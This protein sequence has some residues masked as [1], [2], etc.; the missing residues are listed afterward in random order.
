MDI[1]ATKLSH[2]KNPDMCVNDKAD[3]A[4]NPLTYFF[5]YCID[6]KVKILNLNTFFFSIDPSWF[7]KDFYDMIILFYL[8][9]F[10]FCNLISLK[11]L[12]NVKEILINTSNNCIN[13]LTNFNI[14]TFYKCIP[15]INVN[16][17]NW[18]K[19]NLN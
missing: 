13:L 16:V 2:G 9:F 7:P 8:Y 12:L 4:F 17:N 19:P 18:S 5:R 6:E 1:L 11:F 15:I 10:L 3:R 14:D